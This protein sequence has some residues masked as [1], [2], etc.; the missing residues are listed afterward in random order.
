MCIAGEKGVYQNI[1][2]RIDL[3]IVPRNK[4]QRLLQTTRLG[5][6]FQLHDSFLCAGGIEGIDTCKVGKF[7]LKMK[8]IFVNHRLPFKLA[9]TFTS[10]IH[11]VKKFLYILQLV[12]GYLIRVP[13]CSHN[14]SSC[15][16]CRSWWLDCRSWCLDYRSWCLD[17]RSWCL[18]CLGV[19]KIF[20]TM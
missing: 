2:K 14:L 7:W 5:S 13:I 1:L 18:D 8:V 15:L 19:W 11:N 20:L 10:D 6:R 9:W 12:H 4:C 3:P 17:S 16:D